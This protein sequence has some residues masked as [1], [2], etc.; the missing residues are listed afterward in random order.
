LLIISVRTPRCPRQHAE[1]EAYLIAQAGDAPNSGGHRF[2]RGITPEATP[3]RI[4]DTRFWKRRHGEVSPAA[5]TSA[6]V[7]S[8]ANCAACH[9]GA[10]QGQFGEEE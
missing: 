6:K 10:A 2:V 5:F 3:L 8:K 7:K 9:A 4:T 1:I